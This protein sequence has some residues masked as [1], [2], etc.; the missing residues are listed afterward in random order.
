[1][2]LNTRARMTTDG[3]ALAVEEMTLN[4][5]SEAFSSNDTA[6]RGID[7]TL[8]EE[9]DRG[10]GNEVLL[11]SPI[12]TVIQMESH[13][14]SPMQSPSH[15]DHRHASP[16]DNTSRHRQ[17][18][19]GFDD[20]LKL[21][22]IVLC[23]LWYTSGA[24]TSNSGVSGLKLLLTL[25]KGNKSSS[26]P[27]SPS[28]SRSFN[29]EWLHSFASSSESPSHTP[30]SSFPPNRLTRFPLQKDGNG[31][32]WCRGCF[33]SL[34]WCSG[35]VWTT[36]MP[37]FIPLITINLMRY[38]VCFGKTRTFGYWTTKY[39]WK[40]CRWAFSSSAVTSSRALPW[41]VFPLVSF[42]QSK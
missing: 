13:S 6:Y 18:L 32:W 23:L 28:H 26:P 20:S 41:A 11:S 25:L 4:D 2:Q 8:K 7:Q 12:S 17:E 35:L 16:T 5:D 15:S 9:F 14:N 40:W 27:P 10:G 29:S 42:T 39:S 37:P 30:T 21:R 33:C 3:V 31:G 19:Y 36:T 38:R 22:V 24:L 34:Y 1:M